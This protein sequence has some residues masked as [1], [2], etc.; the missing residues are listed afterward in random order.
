MDQLDLGPVTVML[1]A[2]PDP[3]ATSGPPAVPPTYRVFTDE[4]DDALKELARPATLPS[5]LDF[6]DATVLEAPVRMTIWTYADQAS[7]RTITLA[8]SPIAPAQSGGKPAVFVPGRD[9]E[10][11]SL[12]GATAARVVVSTDPHWRGSR[13]TLVWVRGDSVLQITGRGVSDAEL[14]AAAASL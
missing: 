10:Q 1:A 7:G 6:L 13:A 3:N 12:G 8:S 5:G 11:A 4:T 14:A 9:L 2:I